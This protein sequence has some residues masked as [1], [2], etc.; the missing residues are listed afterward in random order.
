MKEAFLAGQAGR[1]EMLLHGTTINSEFYRG[2]KFYPGTPSAGC[3]VAGETWSKVNGVMQKSDQLDLV[4]AFTR[5][6]RDRGYLVVV[7]L[8]DRD[9]AVT[10]SEV[11]AD[12]DA[13]QKIILNK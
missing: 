3:L 2:A 8:D 7:E 6:G 12:L 1:D 4:K 10:L 5:D 13:A 11:Q 9:V